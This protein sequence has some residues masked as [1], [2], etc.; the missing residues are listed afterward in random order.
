MRLIRR[1]FVLLTAL[2]AA[3]TARAQGPVADNAAAD[4]KEARYYVPAVPEDMA[5][6]DFFLITGGVGDEVANRFGHTGIRVLD[7]VNK[8]DVVFNW[9]KFSFNQ[10]GFL[11]KFFRGSLTYSMGVRTF[12][13]DKNHYREDERRLVMEPLHLTLAQKRRLL[14][15]IA[16]NAVPEHR[17]FAYQYW[18]KNC[19]TIPR[20]DLDEVLD[21]QVRAKFAGR[22]TDKTFRH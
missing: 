22:K 10:P 4:K 5:Q 2:A 20:D 17:D 18:F 7:H 8:M 14:E 19:A 3:T 21:G 11:W 1:L 6:V 9:G 16:W 15:K 12:A 13:A